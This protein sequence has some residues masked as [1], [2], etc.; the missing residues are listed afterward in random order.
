MATNIDDNL[1]SMPDWQYARLGIS[2]L[3]NNQAERA[4]RMF[5]KRPDSTQVKAANGFLLF[6][7]AL[8]SFEEEKLQL[9]LNELK[10]TEKQCANESFKSQS[11]GGWFKSVKDRLLPT[12]DRRQSNGRKSIAELQKERS[13]ELERRVISADCQLC[14]S[15]LTLLQQDLAGYMKGA[16]ALRRA[17]KAYR[18]A[19]SQILRLYREAF[20]D[21]GGP[22]DNLLDPVS[23]VNPSWEPTTPVTPGGTMAFTP[24]VE[25]MLPLNI[26]TPNGEHEQSTKEHNHRRA[27]VASNASSSSSADSFASCED[28]SVNKTDLKSKVKDAVTRQLGPLSD[29]P[30]TVITPNPDNVVIKYESDNVKSKEK[31]KEPLKLRDSCEIAQD[32]MRANVSVAPENDMETKKIPI[33]DRDE[34]R[35]SFSDPDPVPG[36]NPA[37]GSDMDDVQ[38]EFG[39]NGYIQKSTQRVIS[40]SSDSERPSTLQ[41]DSRTNQRS[42]GALRWASDHNITRHN[43]SVDFVASPL[44]KSLKFHG[45]DQQRVLD[46]AGR[47]AASTKKLPIDPENLARLMSAV[48]FGYGVFQLAVSLLPPSLLRVV[49]FLG[50][51]GDRGAGLT[52]LAFARQGTDMRAPLA[53]LALLWYHTIVRPFF[54]IDGSAGVGGSEGMSSEI[55]EAGRLIAESKEEFSEAALFLYFEGRVE[56]LKCDLPAAVLA[57]E[58]SARAAVQQ[59]IQLLCLHE[60]GWCRLMQRDFSSAARCFEEL[61]ARSRWSRIFYTFLSALCR[62]ASG[63]ES[64]ARGIKAEILDILSSSDHK[65][66]EAQVEKYIGR[67][68]L[69]FPDPEVATGSQSAAPDKDPTFWRMY[70]YEMLILWNALTS[71]RPEEIESIIIEC[72]EVKK[73]PAPG[74]SSLILGACHA[75]FSRWSEA[76]K[77]YRLAIEQKSARSSRRGSKSQVGSSGSRTPPQPSCFAKWDDHIAAFAKYELAVVLMVQDLETNR[78]EAKKW[79]HEAQQYKDYDFENRLNVR[80]HAALKRANEGPN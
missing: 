39:N 54:A 80:I 46:E 1:D 15:L 76:E 12:S 65:V 28:I 2:L 48:S 67:R 41:W 79:L 4:E 26:S 32:E 23:P 57:Y 47:G 25:N 55:A 63:N 11:S 49:H 72:L 51:E 66:Y 29:D 62:G 9:A 70:L 33:R 77:S 6:M 36:T 19:H 30:T 53:T 58:R 43:K 42:D 3:L 21:E 50:F 35:L 18:S 13:D 73:E 16:W 64:D 69:C 17:W 37:S 40:N 38:E 52:S 27:S 24:I 14:S 60:I 7:N 61:R 22:S 68:V 10:E 71:C 34:M 75:Y 78:E 31:T 74:L 5:Q 59:E 56:R 8:M 44:Q 45:T 20:R